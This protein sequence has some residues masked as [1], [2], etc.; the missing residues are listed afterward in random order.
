MTV[1][2]PPIS[3][4]Y[5]MPGINVLVFDN[6]S[7]GQKDLIGGTFIELEGD[8]NFRLIGEDGRV[9]H[10]LMHKPPQF[11]DLYY[12]ATGEQKGRLFMGITLLTP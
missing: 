6:D 5:P 8:E 2:L 12:F 10:A 4:E 11:Y 7:L 1:K 3:D 9:V